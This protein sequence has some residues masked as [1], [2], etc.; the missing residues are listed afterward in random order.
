[1][2][3]IK[4]ALQLLLLA[5]AGFAVWYFFFPPPEKVIRKNLAELAEDVSASPQG[6]IATVANVNSIAGYF[7]PQV[8]LDLS[9]FGRGIE[10][11]N[12]RG[13]LQ[14]LAMGARQNVRSINVKFNNVHV[15]VAEDDQSARVNLTAVVRFDGAE[16]PVVQDI[17]VL[18]E[19][20]ERDWLIRTIQPIQPVL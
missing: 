1:M 17:V 6:N 20:V 4:P 2:R 13:E 9:G 5:A 19:K 14:R 16:Q 12:S 7:H 11:I 15:Q 8:E 3:F 18:F 10:T